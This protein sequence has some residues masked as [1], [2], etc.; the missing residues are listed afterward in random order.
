MCFTHQP[1]PGEDIFSSTFFL[2]TLTCA[3][4]GQNKKKRVFGEQT[5]T[6]LVQKRCIPSFSPS[7]LSLDEA[8]AFAWGTFFLW[9]YWDIL[10]GVLRFVPRGR[11]GAVS[12]VTVKQVWHFG[13]PP[14][15][16]G[17]AG[18]C[19]REHHGSGRALILAPLS[20]PPGLRVGPEGSSPGP[21]RR[22]HCRRERP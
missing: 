22:A 21:R 20:S 18:R 5:D 1:G 12:A 15:A 9:V 3:F 6:V 11:A 10:L 17:G 14:R 13:S 16:P 4:M 7:L 8:K 19:R 2:L